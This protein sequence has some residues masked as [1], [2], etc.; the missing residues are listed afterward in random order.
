[1]DWFWRPLERAALHAQPR[2]FSPFP[3]CVC[4]TGSKTMKRHSWKLL[5]PPWGRVLSFA[6]VI[7]GNNLRYHFDF[8][9]FFNIKSKLHPKISKLEYWKMLGIRK[10]KNFS[11][12][13]FIGLS[14]KSQIAL[15]RF[16]FILILSPFYLC[17][18]LG[19]SFLTFY[20]NQNKN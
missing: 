15:F 4:V 8:F 2:L 10:V 19:I 18:K 6:V 5:F 3:Q 12:F 11:S 16:K 1:M 20:Q 9:F 17:L 7:Y 14:C 13:F